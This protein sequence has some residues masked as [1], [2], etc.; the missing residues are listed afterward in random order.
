MKRFFLLLLAVALLAGCNRGPKLDPV[1]EAYYRDS[2]ASLTE[3][4]STVLAAAY[5]A[6]NLLGEKTDIPDWEGYPVELWE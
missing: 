6:E 4:C 5:M 1:V 2:L 3:R